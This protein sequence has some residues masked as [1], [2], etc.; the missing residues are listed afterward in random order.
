MS[1]KL[2]R[3]SG[4]RCNIREIK[5]E[6]KLKKNRDKNYLYFPQK[7]KIKNRSIIFYFGTFCVKKSIIIDDI[8][9]IVSNYILLIVNNARVVFKVGH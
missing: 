3:T 4:S 7:E 6:K 5:L 9:P 8:I 1:S 2:A